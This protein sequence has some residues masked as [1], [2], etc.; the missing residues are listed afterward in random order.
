MGEEDRV[1]GASGAP[2][3]RGESEAGRSEIMRRE[4][5]EASETDSQGGEERDESSS[6]LPACPLFDS[7]SI[8]T[9]ASAPVSG[10]EMG[11]GTE[12]PRR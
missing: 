4:T 11:A 6:S 3:T 5:G 1:G 10:G 9:S 2:V 7:Y 12:G 8:T